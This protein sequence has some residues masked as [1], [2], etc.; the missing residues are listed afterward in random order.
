MYC[1]IQEAWPD[2]TFKSFRPNNIEYF[3]ENNKDPLQQNPTINKLT[4]SDNKCYSIIEHIESCPN[5]KNYLQQ[6][7]GSTIITELLNTNPQLKET[8]LVFLIGIAILL[9][10]N[11]FYK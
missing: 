6:K 10:L 8:I 3:S 5:C 11:L 7:Y 9:I 2:Q 4:N 1:S